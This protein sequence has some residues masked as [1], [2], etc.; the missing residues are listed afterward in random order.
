MS[1]EVGGP[2]RGPG[3]GDVVGD[4]AVP[5]AGAVSE[6]ARVVSAEPVGAYARL[7]LAAPGAAASAR[8]GQFAAC[9]TGDTGMLLRRSFSISSA[10]PAAGE[11]VLVVA[12]AGPGTAR[13]AALRAGD[14]LPVLAP[15]GRPFALPPAGEGVVLVGG[16]YG[17]APLAWLGAAL[18]ARGSAVDL[19]VGAGDSCRLLAQDTPAG[20]PSAPVDR[21]HVATEDGSAG[22][23]G[24]VTDVLA[25]LLAEPAAGRRHVF[26][27]GPMAMLRAVHEVA[28]AAGA[29]TQLAT[30]ESMACGIG[31]CMTCVLPVVGED[32]ATRMVRAC[33]EG[34]VFAGDR[35]RWDA[36][37]APA[38]QRPAGVGARVPADAVGAPSPVPPAGGDAVQPGSVAGPATGARS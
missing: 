35:L 5:P 29:A 16:G 36:I 17:A 2:P 9:S 33:T 28:A 8:P 13:I 34:P 7:V 1:P 22:V 37:G 10:D 27:C 18:R 14:E 15:L 30:E 4:E 21:V 31:V 23:R 11:L 26:A 20:T 32:G 3:E 12:A 25:G 24:R 6:R 38:P 19:V